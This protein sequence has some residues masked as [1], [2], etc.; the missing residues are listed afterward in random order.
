MSKEDLYHQANLENSRLINSKRGET[1]E[2]PK[3]TEHFNPIWAR[4]LVWGLLFGVLYML[5]SFSLLIFLTFVF[6]Y[7]QNFFVEKLSRAIPTRALRVVL[8]AVVQLAVIVGL[9][10]FLFPQV[11]MQAS[12]FA[13]RH[14]EYLHTLDSELT[15]YA[16]TYP[17]LGLFLPELI[18]SSP[19]FDEKGL[20]TNWKP[21]D[22]ASAQIFQSLIGT[23][24]KG[25]HKDG[26]EVLKGIV[27]SILGTGSTFLLSLLFSFLILLDLPRLSEA[28]QD[29]RN[30]RLS[31]IYLEVAEAIGDFA[32]VVGSALSAQVLI[33]FVN[34]FLTALGI[35]LLGLTPNLAFLSIVVFLC[36]FI[37]VA[38]VFISSAP[39]C[40]LALQ[41][42]G[43]GLMVGAAV[44][45]WVIHLIEAYILNPQIYGQRLRVN[46]VLVLI[47]LTVA[48]K[49]LGIWGLVL[50]LP[51]C[52]YIFGHAI[53]YHGSIISKAQGGNYQGE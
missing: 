52:T 14:T 33:A 12:I 29:L 19:D 16:Q 38:G 15:K 11:R 31:F 53:R 32:S 51:V 18:D 41:K 40:L 1:Q 45:I 48:G 37:P 5:R 36:S 7:T 30:T 8:V 10:T 21:K 39:I 13:D 46:P 22:S 25:E 17:V 50:G 4:I 44:L 20:L 6:A 23:N 24:E 47:V 28:V 43:A 35:V 2:H 9:F 42:G 34:T 26:S 3:M 49:L 27:A